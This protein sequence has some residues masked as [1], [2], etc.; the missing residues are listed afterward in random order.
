[1]S[2]KQMG[3]RRQTTVFHKWHV[4]REESQDGRDQQNE[5]DVVLAL[6]SRNQSTQLWQITRCHSVYIL[7]DSDTQTE[8]YPITRPTSEGRG[9]AYVRVRPR[10][11]FRVLVMSRSAFN[12]IHY[13]NGVSL[14]AVVDTTDNKFLVCSRLKD[15]NCMVCHPV[16]DVAERST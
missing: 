4:W 8:F 11:N 13:P 6:K 10:S 9:A 3:Q 14:L 1:M 12:S 7:V 5:G 2:S 15:G 16:I